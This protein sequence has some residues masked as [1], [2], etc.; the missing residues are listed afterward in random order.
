MAETDDTLHVQE[1]AVA[2]ADPLALPTLGGLA[3]G[4]AATLQ[5]GTTMARAGMTLSA[6]LVRIGL[7]RSDLHPA[8]ND[9]R[10]KDPTWTNNLAYKRLAQTYL[11]WCRGVDIVLSEVE[12]TAGWQRSTRARFAMDILTSAASPTNSLLGNPGALKRTFETGGANLV[13]GVEHFVADLRH[14]GGMPSMTKPGALKVGEDLAL[15]TRQCRRQGRVR[16]TAPLHP[17]HEERVRTA[18][19]RRAAADRPL[20]LPRPPARTQFR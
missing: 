18:G 16:R 2:G 4:V 10:F 5:Q 6:D 7:G 11:A 3:D 19:P 13:R 20:L 14:N 15:D 1:D 17:D 9:W 8:T 12:Q